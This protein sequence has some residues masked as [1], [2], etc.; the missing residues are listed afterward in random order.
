ML[1]FRVAGVTEYSTL[2]T[3]KTEN[4]VVSIPLDYPHFWHEQLEDNSRKQLLEDP[5][6]WQKT[7]GRSLTTQRLVMPVVPQYETFPWAA[8][9]GR[10]I[11]SQLETIFSD[12]YF[13]AS[14]ELNLLNTILLVDELTGTSIGN[15]IS[16]FSSRN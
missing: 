3:L 16:N 5:A 13:L 11:F 12:R 4:I 2:Q 8:V 14:S 7:L 10:K 9:A 15:S 1:N 6:T